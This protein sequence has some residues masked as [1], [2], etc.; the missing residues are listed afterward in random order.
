MILNLQIPT[1]RQPV[2]AQ[3]SIPVAQTPLPG[4]MVAPICTTGS[5]AVYPMV[6]NSYGLL[7]HQPQQYLAQ[8]IVYPQPIAVSYN[9]LIVSIVLI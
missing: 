6:P 3:P 8:P 1:F 9:F 5:P 7:S 2:G 4:R